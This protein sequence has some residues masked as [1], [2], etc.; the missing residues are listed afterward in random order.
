MII[1]KIL[2][3]VDVPKLDTFQHTV[4]KKSHLLISHHSRQRSFQVL[5]SYHN[6]RC[7]F[8]RILIFTLK[9]KFYH[10]PQNGQLF[11][12]KWHTHFTY[13]REDVYQIWT[14][15]GVSLIL[16]SKKQCS[17]ENEWFSLLLKLHK[18]F[19]LEQSP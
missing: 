12:L 5:G 19:S 4:S 8:S 9:Y 13:F 15:I 7:K 3:Y 17:V 16:P 11:S 18:C 1:G 6:G 10:Q 2:D 14:T